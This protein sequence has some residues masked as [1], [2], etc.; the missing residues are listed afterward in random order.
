MASQVAPHPIGYE[1]NQ[2][3]IN[4]NPIVRMVKKVKSLSTVKIQTCFPEF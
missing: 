4:Q 1:T 3:N 2:K